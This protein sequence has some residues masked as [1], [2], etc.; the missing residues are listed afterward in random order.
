M[1]AARSWFSEPIFPWGS[2]T[3]T[4][5]NHAQLEFAPAAR[6]AGGCRRPSTGSP[7]NSSSYSFSVVQVLGRTTPS[8]NLLSGSLDEAY[9]AWIPLTRPIFSAMDWAA[10]PP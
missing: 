5:K 6:L 1:Y 3:T 2:D 8:A 9:A 4:V 10:F 7:P